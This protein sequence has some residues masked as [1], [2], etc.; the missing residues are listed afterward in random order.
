MA[1][2]TLTSRRRLFWC[3]AAVSGFLHLMAVWGWRNSPH[4]DKVGERHDT[5]PLT[6][7][8]LMPSPPQPFNSPSRLTTQP[9]F[10]RA[11]APKPDAQNA[12]D[13][14]SVRD[15]VRDMEA[16]SA[17][18]VLSTDQMIEAAKRGIGKIDRDLRQA[19]PARSGSAVLGSAVSP[20]AK[21]IAAA[22]LPRGTVVQDVVSTDGQRITKVITSSSTYCVL[23]RKP[24]AGI[25]E[26]ELSAL[27]TTTCPN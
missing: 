24:G 27:I 16:S 3:A 17:Q 2:H 13:Q 11:L 14:S 10:R 4:T 22:G 15:P 20:L 12:P 8:L 9:Q 25:T 26:I 6:V 19:F 1:V 5:S 21:G 23:G 7:T 18:S